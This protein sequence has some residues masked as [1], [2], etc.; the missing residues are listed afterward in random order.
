MGGQATKITKNSMVLDVPVIIMH[1]VGLYSRKELKF[2]CNDVDPMRLG[3]GFGMVVLT[4]HQ[5]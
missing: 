4:F 2:C 5:M 1:S 3:S